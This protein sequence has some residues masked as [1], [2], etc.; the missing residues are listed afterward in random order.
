MIVFLL[1]KLYIAKPKIEHYFCSRKLFT[2]RM[3]RVFV[4]PMYYDNDILHQSLIIIEKKN[5]LALQFDLILIFGESSHRGLTCFF[6]CASVCIL[7][8]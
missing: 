6:N 8:Y 3:L 1:R 2:A 7:D 4:F 5:V